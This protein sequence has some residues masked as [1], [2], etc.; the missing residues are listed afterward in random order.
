MKLT[1]KIYHE[2]DTVIFIN[3]LS[4]PLRTLKYV[5]ICLEKIKIMLTNGTKTQQC[6]IH[7]HKTFS[8]KVLRAT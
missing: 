8:H 2:M 4:I 7:I 6:D 3:L 1:A 5:L